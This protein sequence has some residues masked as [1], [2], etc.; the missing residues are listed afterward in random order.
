[1]HLRN[2]LCFEH[3]K[4]EFCGISNQKGWEQGCK[5]EFFYVFKVSWYKFKL[6]CFN[7]RMVNV[8]PVVAT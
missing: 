3:I 2:Y 6:E 7:F 4:M 8:I 5:E 1:M